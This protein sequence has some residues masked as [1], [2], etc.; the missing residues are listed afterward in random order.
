LQ[1]R[2][3]ELPCAS[4]YSKGVTIATSSSS[5]DTG[6]VSSAIGG[7]I[8]AVLPKTHAIAEIAQLY[9]MMREYPS[10]PGKMIRSKLLIAS[11]IAHGATF[12]QALPLAAA[13]ELFQNW[14]L[15]HDDIED[16]SDE[17]R[18]KPAL[19]RLYPTALAINAGDALHIYMWQVVHQAGVAGAFEEFLEMIHR[20]AEGQQMDLAWVAQARWDVSPSDYL[21]MVRLKTA[22]YTVVSPLKLGALAAGCVPDER[23]ELA[24]LDLGVAFQIRDDVLNLEGDFA[25]YG[26]EIAGDILEG[27]RTLMLLHMLERLQS[28]E[29][30]EVVQILEKPR[31]SK[32]TAEVERILVLMR[33]HGSIDF[34]QSVAADF[35]TR[36]L[37]L[38]QQALA[39]LPV[40]AA[41]L[42]IL[43][44]AK[45]F[46]TRKT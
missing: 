20:T 28:G 15:I 23:L 32:T 6:R 44:T 24:G 40:Q 26:K 4:A 16:D 10:R 31:L 33:S 19:H 41:A 3:I 5:S 7:F 25:S 30:T 37:D 36:G 1:S 2:L 18:G 34:A 8:D 27:K 22:R 35:E 42:E 46:V 9:A 45:S 12:E 38:L 14:V 13:L 29:K 39:D 17:R 21:E 43:E 11:A